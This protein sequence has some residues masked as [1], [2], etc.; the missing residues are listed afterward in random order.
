[1]LEQ[2]EQIA[3]KFAQ[4]SQEYEKLKTEDINIPI[5][6]EK[7]IPQ[8]TED[9][10]RIILSQMDTNKSTV[11]GDIPAALLKYVCLFFAA[12]LTDL[13][14]IGRVIIRL[15]KQKLDICFTN[16]HSDNLAYL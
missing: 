3:D 8:F 12:S 9:E 14:N 10:V 5:F 15:L 1:M 4:V 7:E 11:N 2:A 6:A 13:F 16:R